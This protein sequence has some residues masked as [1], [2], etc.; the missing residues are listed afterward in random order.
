MATPAKKMKLYK[1]SV[2]RDRHLSAAQ[3]AATRKWVEDELLELNLRALRELTGKTQA[4][5]AKATK[6]TQSE[7]SRA[8]HRDDHLVS[9][10][11][12]LVKAL[13]GELEVRAVFDDRTVKL[14]GV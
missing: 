1:W 14:H 9:S 7:V 3:R 11:R 8:E 2:V 6:M 12:A 10:L 13:G 4:E 5:I